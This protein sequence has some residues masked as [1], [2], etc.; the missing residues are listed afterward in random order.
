MCVCAQ[1][2]RCVQIFATP[3]TVAPQAP[4]S[5]GFSRQ[6]YW[7]G[8]PFPSLG[9]LPG[10]GIEL[11]SLAPPALAGEFFTMVPLGKTQLFL[12]ASHVTS[13]G[14]LFATPWTGTHKAPLS[15][16]FSRQKYWSGLPFPPPRDLPN[17]GI[18]PT[19]PVSP[20][21][22]GGFFTNEPPGKLQVR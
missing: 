4:L 6:E 15:M 17:P 21:L 14:Q 11:A 10:L 12:R 19:S 13:H 3:G 9:D 8:L 7:S 2:L 18:K 20:A 1:S 5:I 16:G 22:A